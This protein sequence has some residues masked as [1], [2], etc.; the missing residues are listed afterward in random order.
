MPEPS[1]DETTNATT[2]AAPLSRAMKRSDRAASTR[3]VIAASTSENAIA[4]M[5]RK[6][7]N[8]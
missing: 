6:S 4:S 5:K 7:G 3:H 8:G 1:S 2:Y